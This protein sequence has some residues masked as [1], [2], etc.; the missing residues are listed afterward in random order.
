MARIVR[1]DG[2]IIEG[3]PDELVRFVERL[4]G[5]A[6]PASTS[7]SQWACVDR[8]FRDGTFPAYVVGLLN[9]TCGLGLTSSE[10]KRKLGYRSTWALA[11]VG[12]SISKWAQR[13]GLDPGQVY[14]ISTMDDGRKVWIPGPKS[15]EFIERIQ[16]LSESEA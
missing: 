8:T 4:N 13:V 10:L 12:C 9:D 14:T 5:H 3:S 2:T 16:K 1:P 15:N 7:M 6:G 11:P